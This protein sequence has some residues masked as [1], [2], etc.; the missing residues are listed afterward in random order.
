MGAHFE[1]EKTWETC[2]PF[3]TTIQWHQEQASKAS[4]KTAPSTSYASIAFT[5]PLGGG[6]VGTGITSISKV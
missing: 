2:C 5:S 1:E 3:Q 4:W 6:K